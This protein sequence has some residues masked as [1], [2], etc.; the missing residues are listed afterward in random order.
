MSSITPGA[1]AALTR[2]DWPGNVRELD[3]AIA[4]AFVMGD[5]TT[6][7]EV[8][9]PPEIRGDEHRDELPSA[10]VLAPSSLPR[11]NE[12]Q[13]LQTAL[14]R[15]GGHRGR[16]A[17]SLGISRSTLWRRLRKHRAT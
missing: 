6:L 3:N 2:Y 9:L 17:A 13:R 12:L 5:G 8:E 10:A 16:A 11:S 14:E 4:Y 1:L 15:A 7:T